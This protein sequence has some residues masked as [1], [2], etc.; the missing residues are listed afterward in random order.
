MN[1]N[2]RMK[3]YQELD[4][5]SSWLKAHYP[6][7]DEVNRTCQLKVEGKI[8]KIDNNTAGEIKFQLTDDGV[9]EEIRSKDRCADL[10]LNAHYQLIDEVNKEVPTQS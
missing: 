3:V 2:S 9:N 10:Q 4:C 5:A 7:I 8:Q 6:L 1:T